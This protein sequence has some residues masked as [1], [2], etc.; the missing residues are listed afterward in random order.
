[1]ENIVIRNKPGLPVG[2][3]SGKASVSIKA[4]LPKIEKHETV[5][6]VHTVSFTAITHSIQI[7]KAINKMYKRVKIIP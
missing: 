6:I 2:R 3:H 7:T 4:R 1:M 5:R